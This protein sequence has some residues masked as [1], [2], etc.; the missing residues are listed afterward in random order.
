VVASS[1]EQEES[2]ELAAFLEHA[3]KEPYTRTQ[4]REVYPRLQYLRGLATSQ[5][6][7][8]TVLTELEKHYDGWYQELP[9]T[10]DELET[11]IV[12]AEKWRFVDFG[13]G[14]E[15]KTQYLVIQYE[16]LDLNE[17]YVYHVEAW[18]DAEGTGAAKCIGVLPG[19]SKEPVVR[20]AGYSAVR[21]CRITCDDGTIF[22]APHFH[23]ILEEIAPYHAEDESV[24]VR[25]KI[26]G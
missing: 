19:D 25:E 8:S 7:L 17:I 4:Q 6:E 22:Y 12:V 9:P 15:E 2:L 14:L 3:M 21:D 20:R 24:P 1:K 5:A 13:N 23:V 10:F 11:G 18:K 26:F 16:R